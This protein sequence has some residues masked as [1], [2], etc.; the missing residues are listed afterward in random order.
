MNN[1]E[2]FFNR[3]RLYLR[4][5]KKG[6]GAKTYTLILAYIIKKTKA[7]K[8]HTSKDADC[9]TITRYMRDL[10]QEHLK[11]KIVNHGADL[12]NMTYMI[13]IKDPVTQE[14]VGF[15]INYR[16]TAFKY[17]IS[18]LKEILETR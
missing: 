10:P 1:T 14:E 4:G 3:I 2:K 5:Q 13:E 17:N 12:A 8:S 15:F 11:F 9:I 18:Y 7:L 6:I 16:D